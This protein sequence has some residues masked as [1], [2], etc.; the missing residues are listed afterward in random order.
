MTTTYHKSKKKG[1][2][3]PDMTVYIDGP[4]YPDPKLTDDENRAKLAK[5]AYDSMVK[6]SKKNSYEYFQYRKKSD[7]QK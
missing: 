4:F 7:S 6:Y 3:R 5:E 1:Q 2:A